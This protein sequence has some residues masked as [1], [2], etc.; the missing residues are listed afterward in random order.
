MKDEDNKEY[1]EEWGLDSIKEKA[2]LP[3]RARF[4][5]DHIY[6]VGSGVATI[7]ALIILFS[8]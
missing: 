8:K 6:I 5:A 7:L 1:Q 2:Y 3:R 4:V